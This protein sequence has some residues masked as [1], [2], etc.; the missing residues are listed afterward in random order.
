MS[1]SPFHD[2][3]SQTEAS[4]IIK[5]ACALSPDKCM[6]PDNL[7]FTDCEYMTAKEQ[8][9]LRKVC[10]QHKGGTAVDVISAALKIVEE[11]KVAPKEVSST[12][13]APKSK[14]TK[15]PKAMPKS[16]PVKKTKTK[17]VP[18]NRALKE[19]PKEK[20]APAFVMP[21]MIEDSTVKFDGKKYV[22]VFGIRTF[23]VNFETRKRA[24]VTA[25]KFK[26][27]PGGHLNKTVDTVHL[28]LRMSEADK[29]RWVEG[30]A[31]QIVMCYFV[32]EEAYT[33]PHPADA[34]GEGIS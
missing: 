30:V 33:I 29:V 20:S 32:P 28:P 27:I 24:E 16:K 3:N 8:R 34:Q 12:K 6:D 5:S 14:P 2:E 31:R 17:Q 4:I 23:R 11:T 22:N 19:K 9:Y 13:A 1:R 18:K 25:V 15:K 21:H 10:A 7:D 26:H